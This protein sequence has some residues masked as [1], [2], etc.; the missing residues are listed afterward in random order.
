MTEN[1]NWKLETGNCPSPFILYTSTFTLRLPAAYS[2]GSRT[3]ESRWAAE[4]GAPTLFLCFSP[5]CLRAA[6][7]AC[8]YCLLP[9]AYCLLPT[10]YCLLPTAYCFFN[11]GYDRVQLAFQDAEG[12][13][14]PA[15]LFLRRLE[16]GVGLAAEEHREQTLHYPLRLLFGIRVLGLGI[17]RPGLG[18]WDSGFRV[19]CFVLAGDCPLFPLTCS[20]SW[21]LASGF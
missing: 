5:F 3:S 17:R 13:L 4:R 2:G 18:I 9:T 1:R 8:P 15:V 14:H 16:G 19:R 7:G 20:L 10:A 6:A 12:L 21:L 11:R